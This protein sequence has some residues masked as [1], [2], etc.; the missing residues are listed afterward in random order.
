MYSKCRLPFAQ[1]VQYLCIKFNGHIHTKYKIA[2]TNSYADENLQVYAL[3]LFLI[4]LYF[5]YFKA[6]CLLALY[7]ANFACE[8]V[9]NLRVQNIPN[10]SFTKLV[11]CFQ[12]QTFVVQKYTKMAQKQ[13]LI[14]ENKKGYFFIKKST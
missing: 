3:I 1:A 12:K 10:F 13:T 5:L 8:T 7:F 9:S 4:K 6:L 11:I 2:Y 14:A